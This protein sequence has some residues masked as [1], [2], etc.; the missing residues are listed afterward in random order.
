MATTPSTNQGLPLPQDSEMLKDVPDFVKALALAVEP[1]LVMSFASQTDL[2]NRVGSPVEGM[3]AWL[4][5]ANI[6]QVYNGSTWV[7]VYPAS[8]T[9]LYGDNPPTS[10]QGSVGDIYV[11]Y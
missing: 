7:K 6:L 9:I 5:D 11:E 4:R 8:P 10:G 2:V 3:V 1:K